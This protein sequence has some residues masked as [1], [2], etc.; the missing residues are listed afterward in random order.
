M[1]SY[2]TVSHVCILEAGF[3]KHSFLVDSPEICPHIV[4]DIVFVYVVMSVSLVLLL[5]I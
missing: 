3:R 1:H 2:Q 4:V 5:S